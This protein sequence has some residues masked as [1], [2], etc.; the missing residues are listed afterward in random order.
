MLG[1]IFGS[2]G[3]GIVITIMYFSIPRWL[4]RYVNNC[5]KI[6]FG[7]YMVRFCV[8]YFPLLLGVDMSYKSD[9]LIPIP[10]EIFTILNFPNTTLYKI[11]AIIIT[12]ILATLLFKEETKE[13]YKNTS[14][15]EK[16]RM[17]NRNFFQ[18]MNS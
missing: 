8:R 13:I 4:R 18:E 5:F 14:D 10:K 6:G 2:I 15:D 1:S 9:S 17:E 12:L 11:I 7:F 3:L 16:E